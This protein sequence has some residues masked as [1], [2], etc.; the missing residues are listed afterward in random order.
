MIDFNQGLRF[1]YIPIK[2]TDFCH[3]RVGGYPALDS[4]HSRE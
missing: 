4:Q 2:I 3:I 1:T